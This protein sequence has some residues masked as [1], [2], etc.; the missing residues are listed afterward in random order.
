MKT[1]I[2]PKFEPQKMHCMCGAEMQIGT[3]RGE[4]SVTICSQCHPFFTGKQKFVDTAGRIEKFQ[5]RFSID[6]GQNAAE[7][8][9]QFSG[10]KKKRQ[11]IAAEQ[12]AREKEEARVKA[13][14]ERKAKEKEIKAQARAEAAKKKQAQEA[15]AA[16]KAEAEAPAPEA[17]PAPADDV[18]APKAEE[19]TPKTDAADAAE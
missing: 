18:P 10:S 4:I 19:A 8:A 1:D 2:H 7:A 6:E 16:A 14:A 13:E 15:A 3:T 11:R 5:R 9:Q 12:A 17:T